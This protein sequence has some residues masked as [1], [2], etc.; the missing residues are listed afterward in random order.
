[1]KIKVKKT[2]SYIP[3]WNDN[4]KEKDPMTVHFRFLTAGERGEFVGVEPVKFHD[5]EPEIT[6]KQDNSGLAKKMI[7][8]IENFEMEVG[9]KKVLIDDVTK[10]YETEGIPAV[11]I[12]EIEGALST[13]SAVVDT[14]PLD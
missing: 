8:R 7:T 14:S 9:T 5:G 2:D 6:V 13:A 12:K 3:K 4:D 1:M 11:L 10:L